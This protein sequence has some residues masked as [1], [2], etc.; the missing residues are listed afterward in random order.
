[1]EA[2]GVESARS[3][4]FE[5]VGYKC[6]RMRIQKKY[7]KPLDRNFDILYIDTAFKYILI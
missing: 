1:M 7:E 4:S 3:D 5:H 2:D 6:D